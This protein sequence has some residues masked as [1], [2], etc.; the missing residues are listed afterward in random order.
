MLAFSQYTDEQLAAF[1]EQHSAYHG[2]VQ[3]IQHYTDAGKYFRS[4]LNRIYRAA[5]GITTRGCDTH[6]NC[7]QAGMTGKPLIVLIDMQTQYPELLYDCLAAELRTLLGEGQRFHIVLNEIPHRL[8]DW[9]QR[10]LW[11]LQKNNR[12]TVGICTENIISW[13]EEPDR[14]VQMT[15]SAVV[16]NSTSW[17]TASLDRLL[18][19]FGTYDYYEPVMSK[20]TPAK[21]FA[22]LTDE[23][24][25]A[26]HTERE[27]VRAVDMERFQ[28][29]LKGHQGWMIALARQIRYPNFVWNMGGGN[30]LFP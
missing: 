8:N 10:L 1:G 27:R 6:F 25:T 12:N 23:H 28:A 20:G 14:L 15:Q 3:D 5:S 26:G 9:M 21:L 4:M 18:K 7:I 17:N 29:L 16:L 30:L 13:S 2:A 19:S 24:W 22:V 11:D